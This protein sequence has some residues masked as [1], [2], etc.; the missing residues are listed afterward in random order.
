MQTTSAVFAALSGV[1][2]A[3]SA[4]PLDQAEEPVA[5]FQFADLLAGMEEQTEQ[6]ETAAEGDKQDQAALAVPVLPSFVASTRVT[7]LHLTGF[8]LDGPYKASV[9]STAEDAEPAVSGTGSSSE[10]RFIPETQ[11]DAARW[12]SPGLVNWGTMQPVALPA[13]ETPTDS[14]PVRSVDMVSIATAAGEKSPLPITDNPTAEA[15]TEAGAD[16]ILVGQFPGPTPDT[17][18]D[19]QI[20][21]KRKN[22]ESDAMPSSG[23]SG[24]LVVLQPIAAQPAAPLQ[25]AISRDI[26]HSAVQ[27]AAVDNRLTTAPATAQDPLPLP[28]PAIPHSSFAGILRRTQEARSDVSA[29]GNAPRHEATA[30]LPATHIAAPATTVENSMMEVTRAPDTARFAAPLE[31]SAGQ[32]SESQSD[33]DVPAEAA[34][35]Q[36]DTTRIGW[37][38][39]PNASGFQRQTDSLRS[40][41]APAANSRT[42]EVALPSENNRPQSTLQSLSVRVGDGDERTDLRFV[43][44]NGNVEMSVRAVSPE[45]AQQLSAQLPELRQKLASSGWNADLQ[46]AMEAAGRNHAMATVIQETIGPAQSHYGEARTAEPVKSASSTN[47]DGDATGNSNENDRHGRRH[48]YLADENRQGRRGRRDWEINEDD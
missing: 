37:T 13:E 23:I 39:P 24:M 1:S 10:T 16:A 28:T 26:H 45:V 19:T 36:T 3:A 42:T 29:M 41:D 34:K 22:A 43:H 47:S 2:E 4:R 14:R 9:S 18:G 31:H 35:E 33:A 12:N 15:V 21:E 20:P 17:G 25:E 48:D 27:K 32:Q 44:R 30:S 8:G 7:L 11:R 40:A 6:A 46:P 38:S 5:G